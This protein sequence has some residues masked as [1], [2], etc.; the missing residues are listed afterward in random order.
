MGKRERERDNAY[1]DIVLCFS[2]HKSILTLRKMRFL[3]NKYYKFN[4]RLL[5]LVGLWPYDHSLFRYCQVIFC[6]ITTAFLMFFQVRI[7]CKV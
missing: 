7:L 5:L 4:R 6:N 3:G 2:E 1:K